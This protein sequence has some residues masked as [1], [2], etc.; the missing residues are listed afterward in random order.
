[1]DSL[2]KVK[3]LIGAKDAPINE[4]I[5]KKLPNL[6]CLICSSPAWSTLKEWN[7]SFAGE[8]IMIALFVDFFSDLS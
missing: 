1:M 5:A 2:E 8:V 7:C 4:A 3:D 6:P